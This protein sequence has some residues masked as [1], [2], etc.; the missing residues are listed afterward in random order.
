MCFFLIFLFISNTL[1]KKSRTLGEVQGLSE[2]VPAISDVEELILAQCVKPEAS[3]QISGLHRAVALLVSFPSHPFER[4]L[5]A[6]SWLPARQIDSSELMQHAI[7]AWS[8]LIAARPDL[9]L[10]LLDKLHDAWCHTVDERKGLFDRTHLSSCESHR[11]WTGFL[12]EQVFTTTRPLEWSSNVSR[13]MLH[14]L[15]Y[16][17][18]L[19]ASLSSVGARF[20]LLLLCIR[21]IND[22]RIEDIEVEA[23][24]RER[25][26]LCALGWFRQKP[27]WLEGPH[28]QTDVSTLI[29]FCVALQNEVGSEKRSTRRKK[30]IMFLFFFFFF[31]FFF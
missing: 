1:E 2:A 17:F 12:S 28:L 8:W 26:F 10:S 3:A 25:V 13:V 24:L 6:L 16:A 21:L 18:H 4:L 30:L 20:E 14:A 5:D 19:N 27:L 22:N 9:E 7:F 15:Q 29:S 11:L 31:F 23:L